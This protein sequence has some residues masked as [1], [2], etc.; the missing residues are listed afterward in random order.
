MGVKKSLVGNKVLKNISTFSLR[1]TEFKN[2]IIFVYQFDSFFH[3][4][5]HHIGAMMFNNTSITGR[6]TKRD[7]I[8]HSLTP[9][10]RAFPYG[11]KRSNWKPEISFSQERFFFVSVISQCKLSV[12]YLRPQDR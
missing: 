2:Q 11:F 10:I 12:P 6:P 3:K 1:C 8:V 5:R 4:L 9:S 7:K